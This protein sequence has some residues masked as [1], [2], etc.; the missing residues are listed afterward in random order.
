MKA[1]PH[2]KRLPAVGTTA[3]ACLRVPLRSRFN[4]VIGLK[5]SKEG[6]DCNC[7]ALQLSQ[8]GRVRGSRRL[9]HRSTDREQCWES[10]PEKRVLEEVAIFC[11]SLHGSSMTTR[12]SGTRICNQQD[13]VKPELSQGTPT[14]DTW[15]D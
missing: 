4:L 7:W 11:N 2:R 14:N 8:Y 6:H 10:G 1:L 9:S 3:Q 5:K 15:K 12:P 13:R